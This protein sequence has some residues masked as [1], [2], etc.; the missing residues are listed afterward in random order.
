MKTVFSARLSRGCFPPRDFRKLWSDPSKRRQY[1]RAIALVQS[2][3]ADAMQSL[4]ILVLKDPLYGD[5][6][7]I[8]F[9][10]E[11]LGPL[12]RGRNVYRRDALFSSASFPFADQ[13]DPFA[14]PANIHTKCFRDGRAVVQGKVGRRNVT[15]HDPDPRANPAAARLDV[16]KEDGKYASDSAPEVRV[17]DRIAP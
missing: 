4:L 9:L 10:I 11:P 16:K 8:K 2:T 5:R 13:F 15:H 6:Q 7:S 14:H 17:N 3:Q 1:S 12:E